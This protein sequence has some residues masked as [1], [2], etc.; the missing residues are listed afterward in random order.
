VIVPGDPMVVTDPDE[1]SDLLYGSYGLD[2][3]LDLAEA[4]LARGNGVLPPPGDSWRVGTGMGVAMIATLPPRGHFADVTLSVDACGTY[5][6]GVGTADFGSGTTTAHTQLLASAM[7]TR[8]ERIAMRQ[9]D[10]DIVVHDTG[11]F[12]SAGTV[13]AGKAILVAAGVLRARMLEGAAALVGASGSAVLSERG[14]TVGDRLVTFADLLAVTAASEWTA[15]GSD[16]GS[17]RSVAFNV[18]AFRVAV[19]TATGEVRILQS[20]QAA[21]AG[22]V[23]N[24]EQLRGQVEGGTAQAIGTAL[25]EEMR[26]DGEGRV[27]NPEIRN[28]H[29]PQFADVPHTEVYFADTVDAHGPIG[30]KSMSEAPYNPVAPALANAVRDAIGVR[31]VEL[32]MSRDRVWRM[33]HG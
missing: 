6:L 17:P 18:H 23:I 7:N 9:S 27:L 1:D 10:T 31:P 15:T 24:P 25:Y 29:L 20:I 14:V 21:D 4:A 2:Q 8:V 16:N 30:A 5:S 26:L 13:V 22:V 12:G 19:D 3:C 28:Y 32:P 11:A 33:L